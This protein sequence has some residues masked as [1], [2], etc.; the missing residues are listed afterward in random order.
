MQPTIA[1]SR[2]APLLLVTFLLL[3]PVTARAQHTGGQNPSPSAEAFLWSE[4]ETDH[5]FHHL[6]SLHAT[7][8]MRRQQFLNR[9]DQLYLHF[10]PY[11]HPAPFLDIQ[12][13]YVF[14]EHYP[15]PD[16]SVAHRQP[17]H[18]AILGFNFRHFF[19]PLHL[20]ARLRYE[21]RWRRRAVRDPETGQIQESFDLQHETRWRLRASVPLIKRQDKKRLEL[22]LS[23]EVFVNAEAPDRLSQNRLRAML[24][25]HVDQHWHLEAGYMLRS[26]GVDGRLNQQK[27]TT[28]LGVH[29]D[30]YYNDLFQAKQQEH[31]KHHPGTDYS[32]A[33]PRGRPNGTS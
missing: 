19:E 16:R 5:H 27:H 10:G 1:P 30:I 26:T 12:T 28:F 2:I 17:E 3:T 18:R 25:Y 24:E 4:I 7:A 22:L 8:Q 6:I 29:Y 13:G 33:R 15:E 9:W 23:E 31:H 11:W 20:R 14:V 21:P 32:Q